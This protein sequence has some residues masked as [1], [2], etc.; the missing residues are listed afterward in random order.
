MLG[1]WLWIGVLWFAHLP[2]TAG[3]RLSADLAAGLTSWLHGWAV[4]GGECG[5]C[6]VLFKVLFSLGSTTL[7]IPR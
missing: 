2:R 1:Y 6:L 5:W 3:A 7:M 4:G